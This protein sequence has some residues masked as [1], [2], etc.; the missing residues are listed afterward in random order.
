ML[1]LS[2]LILLKCLW[3]ITWMML[4]Q[5]SAVFTS[6]PV[7]SFLWLYYWIVCCIDIL[8]I[9]FPLSQYYCFYSLNHW[10]KTTF[11]SGC[12]NMISAV[13][14]IIISSKYYIWILYFM[15]F[16]FLWSRT[17]LLYVE[18]QKLKPT[19]VSFLFSSDLTA[20]LHNKPR[21]VNF[22]SDNLKLLYGHSADLRERDNTSDFGEKSV[23]IVVNIL[24]IFGCLLVD[25]IQTSLKSS[26]IILKF[27]FS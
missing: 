19:W 25:C 12:C 9:D 7:S 8:L 20:V 11:L 16:S 1:V 21:L 24:C 3:Q 14:V 4:R 15:G 17:V 13:I 23:F 2:K 26:F 22:S 10:S 5:T 6:L 27:F 18:A